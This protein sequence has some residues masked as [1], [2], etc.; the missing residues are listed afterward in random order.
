MVELAKEVK[1]FLLK[2]GFVIVSTIDK[3]GFP[4]ASCKGIVDIADDGTVFLLDLYHGATYKNV[5]SN[6]R[7]SITAVDEHKFKGYTLKGVA[8]IVNDAKLKEGLIQSWE[9][10][11]AARVTQR[12]LRNI[13]GQRGHKR[14]PEALLPAPKYLIAVRPGQ[15]IDLTPQH[16]AKEV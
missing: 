7:L 6:P 16:L 2:Q 10:R 13:S 1:D 12:I 4:H 8:R 5:M 11:I 9:S 3:N 15:V 14:H